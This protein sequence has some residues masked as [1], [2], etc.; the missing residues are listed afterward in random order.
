MWKMLLTYALN[1][2]EQHPELVGKLWNMLVNHFQSTA[3]EAPAPSAPS[4]PAAKA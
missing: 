3:H 2:L 1:Q 4:T